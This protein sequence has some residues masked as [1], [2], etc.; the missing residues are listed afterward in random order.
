MPLSFCT[1]L[2]TINRATSFSSTHLGTTH[3]GTVPL[4]PFGDSPPLHPEGWQ[5]TADGGVSPVGL[6]GDCPHMAHM[7]P[8]AA[9]PVRRRETLGHGT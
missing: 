7:I 9:L 2:S 8:D 3:L 5:G 6:A 4:H 1:S